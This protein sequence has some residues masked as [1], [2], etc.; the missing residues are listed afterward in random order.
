MKERFSW[1]SEDW[2]LHTW[3]LKG[4]QLHGHLLFPKHTRYRSLPSQNGKHSWLGKWFSNGSKLCNK[5][6]LSWVQTLPSYWRHFHQ[7][8]LHNIH[9]QGSCLFTEKLATT[10]VYYVML[11]P[12]LPS[13]PS[14]MLLMLQLVILLNCLVDPQRYR[15][16]L[17]ASWQ[18]N[19]HF[20][21]KSPSAASCGIL[22]IP[23]YLGSYNFSGCTNDHSFT[24]LLGA[25]AVP[26]YFVFSLLVTTIG[27]FEKMATTVISVPRI[28]SV[29]F[30][31]RCPFLSAVRT[32]CEC[33]SCQEMFCIQITSYTL[34]PR[35]D[36]GWPSQIWTAYISYQSSCW[37]FEALMAFVLVVSYECV[38][39]N[40]RIEASLFKSSSL[41][42]KV[43]DH[44]HQGVIQWQKA[45]SCTTKGSDTN[46]GYDLCQV[47]GVDYGDWADAGQ[48]TPSWHSERREYEE[49]ERNKHFLATPTV[50][51]TMNNMHLTQAASSCFDHSLQYH[52]SMAT[53]D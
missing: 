40:I 31:V 37:N 45:L 46:T 50:Q 9:S 35:L 29:S 3:W 33:C 21:T 49:R 18:I 2:L 22:R 25:S 20:H 52:L 15:W 32:Y 30:F 48:T 1:G 10:T 43:Y 13:S 7:N 17:Q 36:T 41:T 23:S 44:F 6:G 34:Y 4:G 16:F 53:G 19:N 47:I 27:W 28:H 26:K 38:F 39:C 5:Q 42:V 12:P 8:I 14:A 11:S 51:V 24:A